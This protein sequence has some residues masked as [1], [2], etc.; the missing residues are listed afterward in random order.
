MTKKVHELMISKSVT[1]GEEEEIADVV[2]KVAKDCETLLACVIDKEDRLIGMIT[3]RELLKAA[4]VS[5]YGNVRHPFFS[6]REVLHLLSSEHA[7]D[8][9]SAPISV[10][11]DDEVQTAI[12]LMLSSN[13][14]EVPVVDKDGKV[15]GE[16]N[17]LGIVSHSVWKRSVERE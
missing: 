16:I 12:D 11:P 5:D 17:F 1:V 8:I 7:R 4:E 15:V 10:K 2:N 14:Y 9:M 3:P 13:L 6:G